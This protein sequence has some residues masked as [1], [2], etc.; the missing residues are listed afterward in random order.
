[1]N[2]SELQLRITL[3]SGVCGV[4]ALPAERSEDELSLL[5]QELGAVIS[6]MRELS[7]GPIDRQRWRELAERSERIAPRAL[8]HRL[9]CPDGTQI[10]I[11][12][13][14]TTRR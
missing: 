1:M 14:A 7:P 5:R 2:S 13:R 4:R 8:P 6:E 11:E 3:P 12:S 9:S 10:T